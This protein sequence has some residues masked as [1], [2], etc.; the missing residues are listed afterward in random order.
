MQKTPKMKTETIKNIE[1]S[2]MYVLQ[3]K[4]TAIKMKSKFLIQNMNKL[5]FTVT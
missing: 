4:Y 2:F 3:M 1:I 5:V